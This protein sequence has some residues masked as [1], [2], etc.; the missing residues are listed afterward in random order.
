VNGD[1][2]PDILCDVDV[3]RGAG[4]TG[5]PRVWIEDRE[6]SFSGKGMAFHVL[7][8]PQG[9]VVPGSELARTAR[10]EDEPSPAEIVAELVDAG[11][12]IPEQGGP[13]AYRLVHPA[14]LGPL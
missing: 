9:T 4:T 3:P 2:L 14:R 6:V 1:G 7:S 13:A 10:G 11:Y 8:Y 5:I 12:L